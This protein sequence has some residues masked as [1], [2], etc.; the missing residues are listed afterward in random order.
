VVGNAVEWYDFAVFGGL[1]GVLST[2]F[3]P[4]SDRTTGLVLTF[5][6]FATSFVARPLGALV[7]GPQADRLGRRRSLVATIT[8][9]SAATFAIG[10]LPTPGHGESAMVVVLVLLRSLQGFSAGGEISGSV[11]FV[12]EYAPHGH[13]GRYA[14]WH[15]TGVFLGFAA[16]ISV[17][18]LVT[19]VLSADQVT[20]WGWRLPFLAAAPLGLVGLY[21]RLKLDEPPPFEQRRHQG[22][23]ALVRELLATRRNECTRGF[24]AAVALSVAFNVWFVFLP[25]FV[26]SHRDIPLGRSLWFAVLGLVVGCLVAPLAGRMSDVLGRR[27]LVGAGAIGVSTLGL[28]AFSGAIGGSS[29]WLLGSS[30]VMGGVIGLMVIPAFVAELFPIHQRATGVGLT[31]GWASAVFG[32][33]APAVATVLADRVG[34]QAV[35]LYVALAGIVGLVGT[36]RSRETAFH[37]V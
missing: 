19:L 16:G 20:A 25:T 13:R 34:E 3:F 15:L 2:V 21:L 26:A 14:G 32:G 18:G 10:V 12:I 8:L 36:L 30:V 5:A 27:V 11:P 1:A 33:T 9:M 35:G 29:S 7:I 6:V 22:R 4:G 31:F 24:A 17:V 28:T 37:E 23:R